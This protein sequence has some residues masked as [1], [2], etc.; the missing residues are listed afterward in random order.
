MAEDVGRIFDEEVRA[1]QA[2]AAGVRGRTGRRGLVGRVMTPSDLTTGEYRRARDLNN[3]NVTDFLRKLQEAPGLRSVLLDKMDQEYQNYR[4]AVERT[5]DAVADV[6]TLAVENLALEVVELRERVAQLEERQAGS[7][8]A[9]PETEQAAASQASPSPRRHRRIRWG[10]NTEEVRRTCFKQLERLEH[11]GEP[12]T[13]ETIK[14][15]VPGMLRWLY[16]EN[17]IFS[18]IEGL[19]KAYTRQNGQKTSAG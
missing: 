1:K 6:V 14:R 17:A 19:R 11:S 8:P 2:T 3:F 9:E 5:L 13:T 18:G 7:G 16:G 10:S 4:L 15:H 12:I